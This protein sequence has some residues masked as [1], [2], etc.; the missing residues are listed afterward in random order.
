MEDRSIMNRLSAVKE[1]S[2]LTAL[3]AEKYRCIMRVFYQEYQRIHFQLYKEEIMDLLRREFP[4]DFSDYSMDQL[5]L[6]LTALVE[7][8]NLI[9]FQDPRRVYTIADYKNKQFRYSMTEASVEIERMA[10]KLETLF[11]EPASLSTNY[12]VRMD[13][14]LEQMPGL[15]HRENRTVSEWWNS[16]QEDFKCVNQNYQDYL[17]EFYSGRSEKILKSI[18]FV[19]HKDRFISYLEE[20]IRE[21]QLHSERI[22]ARLRRLD[23]ALVAEVLEQAVKAELDIPRPLSEQR[24]DLEP[25]IRD[26]IYGR[27]ETLYRW[28]IPTAGYPSESSRVLDITN[29]IIQ[30]IIQNAA[31]IVQLQNWGISRKSDY[32]HYISMFQNCESLQDAHRLA[33]HVFGIQHLR[34]YKVNTERTTDSITS[35][36][37]E[38]PPVTYLLTPRIRTYRPRMEKNSYRSRELEKA[39]RRVAYLRQIEKDR[40][41]VN[42]YISGNR[43]TVADIKETVPES[44]RTTLLRWISIANMSENKSGITEY[45]RSFVLKKEE[46]SCLLRCED[47]DLKM[48]AYVF[49]FRD[50][51]NER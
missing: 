50:Q 25:Y 16:L 10:V 19:I 21:L 15:S 1:A 12:F 20:F 39:E 35:S 24:T 23:E 47:G 41:M 49:E 32:I 31:L 3:N 18:E 30:K 27:W 13:Q 38:E 46:G 9:P 36:T 8:K 7:W 33:A 6:D 40:Q 4:D 37:F 45:G 11:L 14:A 43:L 22:A 26:N 5:K 48:P 2:Y 44:V 17:R 34:H 42:R 51:E 29:E 28:F